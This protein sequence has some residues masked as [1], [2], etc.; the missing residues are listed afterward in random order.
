MT[1]KPHK[2]FISPSQFLAELSPRALCLGAVF[3]VVFASANIYLGLYAGMTISASI[4]AAILAT[5]I[6]QKAFRSGTAL[7][8]TMAQTMAASGESIAAAAIYTLPALLIAGVWKEFDF[9]T[10][11]IVCAGGGLLGIV[12]MQPLR[13]SYIVED[14]GLAYPES[15]ALS[16]II[17]ASDQGGSKAKQVF[18]AVGL[19]ALVKLFS[20]GVVF[21]KAT[22]E[23]AFPLGKTAFFLGTDV[24]PALLGVGYIVGLNVSCVMA[25][26]GALAWWIAI[27][28]LG[29][30]HGVGDDL[31]G[32]YWD[33]WSSQIRYMGVGA[34]M[35][36]G[37]ASIYRVRKTLLAGV[38]E[39]FDSRRKASHSKAPLRT[40]QM[41]SGFSL[42]AFACL[43]IALLF[44]AFYQ[45]L[46][47]KMASLAL[48]LTLFMSFFLV[49]VSGYINGLVGSSNAPVSGITLTAVLTTGF[50]LVVFGVVGTSGVTCVLAIAAAVCSAVCLSGEMAQ[51]LKTGYWLGSTP[52]NHCWAQISGLAIACLVLAPVLT[53]L[54]Q[55]YGIGTG[56]P[57]ALKAPQAT[58]FASIAQAFF[59]NGQ[60]P[61]NMVVIGSGLGLAVLG[62]DR[63]LELRKSG[64]RLPLMA[65]AVGM[66]LP[67]TIGIPM[68][69]GGILHQMSKESSEAAPGLLFASGLVAGESLMGVGLGV[70]MYFVPGVLPL[71]IA[72][73]SLLSLFVLAGLCLALW[74]SANPTSK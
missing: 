51:Q 63:Y 70:V 30:S 56:A 49:A 10:T 45:L 24:S 21:F 33:M 35:V 48:G 25:I 65:V 61:W 39:V 3:A 46:S 13:R 64:F 67:L 12:L 54:H 73:S 15:I 14:S 52:R 41:I 62:L 22:V 29:A 74:R 26:G 7:E 6:L 4:P 2:P 59:G 32:W 9:F 11:T 38:N 66:Y 55:T 28:I 68:V 36:G 8:T 47:P 16:E 37:A 53:V 20:S 27:P 1:S 60:L 57:G 18:R 44:A 43:A 71:E 69:L 40:E 42:A 23:T 72:G 31:L 19:S 58:L 5:A 50:L 17:K 34:M